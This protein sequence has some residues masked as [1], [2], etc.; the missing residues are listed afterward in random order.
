[1]AVRVKVIEMKR[2]IYYSGFEEEN[3]KTLEI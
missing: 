1:M 2:Y 3:K